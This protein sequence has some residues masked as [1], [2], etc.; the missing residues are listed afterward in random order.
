M[1]DHTHSWRYL[2]DKSEEDVFEEYNCPCGSVAIIQYD[3]D[4]R[5]S[6]LVEAFDYTCRKIPVD[7]KALKRAKQQ[8][9]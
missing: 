2:P 4:T 6:V 1:S 8:H 9:L 7:I 5:V 3:A